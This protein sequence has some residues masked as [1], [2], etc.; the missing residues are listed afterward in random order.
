M[1]INQLF[2]TLKVHCPEALVET[3]FE[4]FGSQQVAV[5]ASCFIHRYIH[6]RPEGR[7][8]LELFLRFVLMLRRANVH[9]IF[10]YD[11]KAPLAKKDEKAKRTQEREKI[12]ERLWQLVDELKEYEKTSIVSETLIAEYN[13]I[14]RKDGSKPHK[15]SID[16]LYMLKVRLECRV[17][18]VDANDL[19]ESK[20]LLD[21]L[22][23]PWIVAPGEAETLCAAMCRN[24]VVSVVVSEDSDLLPLECPLT[25]SKVKTGADTTC[26]IIA[27]DDVIDRLDLTSQ[28]FLDFCIMCGTDYN[29]NIKKVGPET[30]LKL[31]H[32]HESIEKIAENT[33]HDVSI[34]NHEEVRQFFKPELETPAQPYC[35][36]PQFCPLQSWCSTRGIP[37]DRENFSNVFSRELFIQ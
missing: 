11:G 30:S 31:I 26:T 20:D 15:V 34:L 25:I 22:E 18:T 1:G 36:I 8:W 7:D 35:G 13:A 5:D 3:N 21:L 28:Q 9:P 23:V 16:E 17:R 27:Y 14:P 19:S 24:Q 2:K 12:E 32:Q 33:S 29:T 37:L 10:V 4:T 6:V